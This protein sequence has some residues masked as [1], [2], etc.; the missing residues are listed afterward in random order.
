[1][2]RVQRSNVPPPR[3]YRPGDEIEPDAPNDDQG[4][5]LDTRP[6]RP[7]PSQEPPRDVLPI[8]A[9]ARLLSLEGQANDARD[10]AASATKRM[11]ELRKGLAYGATA[12][13]AAIDLELT[14]LD[15]VRSAQNRR[16]RE[17]AAVVA[18]IREWLRLV[19]RNAVV[20]LAPTVSARP[21]EGQT[22][23]QAV[24]VIRVKI[25]SL[26]DHISLIEHAPLPKS[27]L[28][29]KA[30]EFVEDLAARGRPRL[31]PDRNS[32]NIAFQD[33]KAFGVSNQSALPYLAWLH[34]DAMIERLQVEV[35]ALPDRANT[36]T[37]AARERRLAEGRS[38]LLALERLEERLIEQAKVSGTEIARRTDASPLAILGVAIKPRKV[39]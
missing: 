28:R 30:K 33:P 32:L 9:R 10:A 13:A 38:D 1:M 15:T 27:L 23:S 14:R 36:V 22:P 35:D 4:T 3:P 18:N 7:R 37:P 34:K 20:E 26:R 12:N 17:L 29:E 21:N 39:A 31:T 19:P 6:A 5:V 25:D 24:E 8:A 16:H 2:N 11:E